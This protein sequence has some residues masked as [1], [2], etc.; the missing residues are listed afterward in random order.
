M[1]DLFDIAGLSRSA[2]PLEVRRVC[3]RLVRRAH[4]DFHHEGVRR[5]SLTAFIA[6]PRV[7][8][9]RRDVAVDF[10]DMSSVLDRM[11]LAFFLNDRA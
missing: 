10:V 9:A 11:Q 7:S 4:P 3:A 1:H 8:P 5:A 6:E 2:P